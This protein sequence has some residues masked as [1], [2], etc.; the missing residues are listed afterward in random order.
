L[1][2]Y[3]K[4]W[5]TLFDA[6]L[7]NKDEDYPI[8]YHDA[9]YTEIDPFDHTLERQANV[10][11]FHCDTFFVCPFSHLERNQSQTRHFFRIEEEDFGFSQRQTNRNAWNILVGPHLLL[12]LLGICRLLKKVI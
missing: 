9:L 11:R 8:F 5:H 2:D 7:Q 4:F 10:E 1:W 3:R 6:L 12:I